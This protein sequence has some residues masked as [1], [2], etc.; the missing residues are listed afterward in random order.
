[1]ADFVFRAHSG[2]RYCVLLAGALT[3]LLALLALAGGSQGRLGRA[4]LIL[5]RVFVGT[6]DLQVLL[7][8]LTVAL[9]PFQ[10]AFIG[11]IVMVVLGAVAAH[12]FA[13]LIKKRA[14]ERRVILALSGVVIALVLIVGGIRAIGRR[15][16]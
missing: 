11:H 8:I 10:P 4:A 14:P 12:Y 16:V 6:L 2:W 9:R 5:Y 13:V 1:M 15:I 3:V 7:G